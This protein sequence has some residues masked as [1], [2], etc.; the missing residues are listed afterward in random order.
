M[1]LCEIYKLMLSKYLHR[2]SKIDHKSIIFRKFALG[3]WSD[4]QRNEQ[5]SPSS[6]F[7]LRLA[8]VH[9]A[10]KRK[11]G[12]KCRRNGPFFEM[13]K[14]VNTKARYIYVRTAGGGEQ[15]RKYVAFLTTR[16]C[17]VTESRLRYPGYLDQ[18]LQAPAKDSPSSSY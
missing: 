18:G 1:S 7:C 16:P 13:L 10:E 15:I 6:L 14:N 2:E 11:V 17:T 3:C 12:A 8:T 5:I 9:R 4:A